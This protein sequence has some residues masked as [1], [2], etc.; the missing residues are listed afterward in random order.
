MNK[1]IGWLANLTSVGKYVKKLLGWL[2]NMTA[3]GQAF[4]E[5]KKMML[6]SLGTAVTG[7][8]TIIAKFSADDGGIQ[9]LLH[10]ASTPEFLA[11]SGWLD[12]LL[13]RS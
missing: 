13:R 11:A 1:L 8:L 3:V 6:A 5:G 4:F 12:S 9:Y 2:A 10:V 7:T